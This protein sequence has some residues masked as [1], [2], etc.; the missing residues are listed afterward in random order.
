MTLLYTLIIIIAIIALA[1]AIEDNDPAMFFAMSIAGTGLSGFLVLILTLFYTIFGGITTIENSK[2]NLIDGSYVAVIS[3][4]EFYVEDEKGE[5][6]KFYK[7][8]FTN[9]SET[10]YLKITTKKWAHNW[11]TYKNDDSVYKEV[12]I[13]ENV[14]FAPVKVSV[15]LEPK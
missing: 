7:I 2:L 11:W 8:N 4:S 5:L 9:S 15:N 12:Y 1:G 13:P 6:V 3:D 10:P 14:K